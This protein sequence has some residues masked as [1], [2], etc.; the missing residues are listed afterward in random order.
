MR[1]RV[2]RHYDLQLSATRLYGRH[3]PA[4]AGIPCE[5]CSTDD[6]YHRE[7]VGDRVRHWLL[8]LLSDDR[9]GRSQGLQRLADGVYHDIDHC[10]L[11]TGFCHVSVLHGIKQT[12][13]ETVLAGVFHVTRPTLDFVEQV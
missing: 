10:G 4:G 13:G 1:D 9:V 5:R 7:P 12:D 11:R 6:I 8:R 2:V 3:Q